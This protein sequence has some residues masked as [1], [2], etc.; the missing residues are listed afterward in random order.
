VSPI[1]DSP[2]SGRNPSCGALDVH[3][4]RLSLFA[5]K[6]ET[7]PRKV[8]VFCEQHTGEEVPADLIAA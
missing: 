7:P 1:A 3:L 8:R 5:A 6:S 4:C 2:R